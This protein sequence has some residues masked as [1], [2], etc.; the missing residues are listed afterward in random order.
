MKIRT[1]PPADEEADLD[2]DV[3]AGVVPVAVAFGEPE[4]D[5]ALR[6]GTP[7]PGHIAALPQRGQAA[8]RAGRKPWL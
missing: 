1:G 2:A 7:L 8:R 5:P 3:W 4:P 6:P